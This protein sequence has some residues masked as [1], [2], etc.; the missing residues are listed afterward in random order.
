MIRVVGIGSPFGDDQAG[1]R[2]V[3]LLRNRL[4]PDIDLVAL[5]R[6]GAALVSW[7]QGADWF[8]LIDALGPDGSPGRVRRIDPDAIVPPPGGTSSHGLDLG[9]AIRLAE[10]LGCRPRHLD[11][12]G[13]EIAGIGTADL[14]A[15]V[16]AGAEALAQRLCEVLTRP[17]DH[18]SLADSPPNSCS[19]S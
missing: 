11:I 2:V 3:E 6:P 17:T 9:E 8:I 13:I 15:A 5:D 1:W 16:E 10:A 12:F 7:M 18:E 4:A 14:C 19:K